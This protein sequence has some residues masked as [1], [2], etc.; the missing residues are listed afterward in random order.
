M[1]I[2]RIILIVLAVLIGLFLIMG[3]VLPKDYQLERSTVIEASPEAVF[4]YVQHFEQ[5]SK[6]YTWSKLDPDMSTEIEGPDGQV[7]TV[8][9]WE[10]DPKTVG[11]GSQEILEVVPNEKVRNKILFEEPMEA[12]AMDYVTLEPVEAG[13]QVT[14]GFESRFPFPWNALLPFMGMEKSVGKDYEEGLSALKELVESQP[15]TAG[16]FRGFEMQ[17]VDMPER[18]YVLLQDRV[19]FEEMEAFYAGAYDK[20]MP[21]LQQAGVQQAGGPTGMYFTWDE[22]GQMT[23]MAAALPIDRKASFPPSF[24]QKTMPAGRVLLVDYTGSYDGLGDVHNAIDAYAKQVNLQLGVPAIEE[25]I[26]GP[27]AEP[28][29]SRW[30]TKVIY[31]IEG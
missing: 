11:S 15:R 4:P 12:E 25:Y 29:S 5:R 7:G 16:R 24:S 20:L 9:E 30:L 27:E 10:G 14:W 28:D 8:Y 26:T 6:W 1:K 23:D 2:L 22:E 17:V 21:A 18:H 13:T 19:S 31:P 3:L